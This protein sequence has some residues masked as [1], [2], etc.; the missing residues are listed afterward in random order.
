MPAGI[1]RAPRCNRKEPPFR[2]RRS[3]QIKSN[4]DYEQILLATLDRLQRS[5]KHVETA[6]EAVRATRERIFSI[7]KTLQNTETVLA[8]LRHFSVEGA[9]YSWAEGL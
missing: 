9:V 6:D 8:H 7:M 2:G 5:K 4:P 1:P 3:L